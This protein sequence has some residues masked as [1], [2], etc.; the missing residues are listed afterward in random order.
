MAADDTSDAGSNTTPNRNGPP[1][2]WTALLECVE[3]AEAG[4]LDLDGGAPQ[5][6]DLAERLVDLGFLRVPRAGCY[7]LTLAGQQLLGRS[8][9]NP[10]ST[11][12][13]RGRSLLLPTVLVALVVAGLWVVLQG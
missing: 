3:T 11:R 5:V 4:V 10:A 7:S 9:T 2:A 1:A 6:V 12:S 13:K 8:T